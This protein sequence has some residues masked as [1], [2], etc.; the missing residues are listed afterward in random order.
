MTLQQLLQEMQERFEKFCKDRNWNPI[1]MG[2][3]FDHYKS[4]LHT[5]VIRLVE[6][7]YKACEVEEQINTKEESD[8]EWFYGKGFNDSLSEVTS[9]KAAFLAELTSNK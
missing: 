3:D 7:A 1:S 8:T 5:E 6:E 4:F 9:K 2:V